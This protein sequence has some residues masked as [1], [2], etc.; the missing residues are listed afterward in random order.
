MTKGLAHQAKTLTDIQVRTLLR[1]AETETHFPER[2]RVVV[3]LSFKA[4]LRAKEIACLTWGMLTDTEGRLT[5]AMSLTNG[6]T[7]GRSGRVIPLHP[8]LKSALEM[9]YTHERERGRVE[10]SA[11]V[12]TLKK[13]SSDA[14]TRSIAS[15]SCSRTGM[16]SSGSEVR[17]RTR[18]AE[19]SSR[20]L[21][22]RSPPSEGSLRDVQLLAGHASIQVTQRYVDA[23]PEAQKK[24]VERL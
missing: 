5:D 14:V 21:P 8:E 2:N 20:R 16:P 19:P 1:F 22:E 4:G 13:G 11:F 9:L 24:L 15:S 7:K 18:G 10:P 17:R 23:D 12:V 3:L 6:A